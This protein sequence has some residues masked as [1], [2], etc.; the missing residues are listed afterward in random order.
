[1]RRIAR[2]IGYSVGTLYNLFENLDDLIVHLN[3]STLESLYG[4][5]AQTSPPGSAESD[6]ESAMLALARDYLGFTRDHARLWNL[7]FEHQLPGGQALS[8]WHHQRIRRLLGVMEQALAPL[9]GPSQEEQRLHTARVLWSSLHGMCALESSN[10]LAVSESIEAM[11]S[12]LV[13]NYLA[14]LR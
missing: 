12:S 1:M 2:E 7:L 14:G 8:E 9:F 11:V 10:K 5:L 13:T 4:T 6:P 3:V